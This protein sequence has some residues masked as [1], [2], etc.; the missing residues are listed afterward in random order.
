MSQRLIR[1]GPGSSAQASRI[2]ARDLEQPVL[3][4]LRSFFGSADRVASAL[5][6]AY[7]DLAITQ[8]LIEAALRYANSMDGESS[9]FMSER[10]SGVATSIVIRQEIVDIY[11]SKAGARARLLTPDA[12][13]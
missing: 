8:T 6:S 7:E 3:I 2:P 13:G 4:E 12:P 1:G 10:L 5:G 11:L 9:S